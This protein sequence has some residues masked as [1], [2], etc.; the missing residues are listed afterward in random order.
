[1]WYFEKT[2]NMMGMSTMKKE[3]G[4]VLTKKYGS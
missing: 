2:P 3:K 4:P 1:M